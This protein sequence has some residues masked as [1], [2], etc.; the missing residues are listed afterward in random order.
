MN[1][2]LAPPLHHGSELRSRQAALFTEGVPAPAE[3][4][5]QFATA[6]AKRNMIMT[7]TRVGLL[8]GQKGSVLVKSYCVLMKVQTSIKDER[9]RSTL[10]ATEVA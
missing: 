9:K 6:T 5:T 3:A 1:S 4:G 10:A 2:E 8:Q 7:D